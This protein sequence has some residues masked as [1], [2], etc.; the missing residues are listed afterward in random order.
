MK[1]EE[2]ISK[3]IKMLIESSEK[4]NSQIIKELEVHHSVVYG[5]MR[6]DYLPGAIMIRKLCKVLG[7]TYEEIL[8]KIE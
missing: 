1:E 7:C 5:Y 2:K 3:N 4:K 8:G 6:G